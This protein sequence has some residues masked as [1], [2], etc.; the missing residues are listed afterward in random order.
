MSDKLKTE[1]VKMVTVDP[2]A[3]V[4]VTVGGG[5]Y[6]R[7]SKLLTDH[8]SSVSEKE[9]IRAMAKIHHERIGDD[10]F[11]YNLHTLMVLIRDIEIAFK[12]SGY[13]AEDEVEYEVPKDFEFMEGVTDSFDQEEESPTP[14]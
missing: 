3:T 4:Q 9:L 13:T 11:A 7:L 1:N 8:A 10:H 12:E 5:F 6:Q 2:D 14:D